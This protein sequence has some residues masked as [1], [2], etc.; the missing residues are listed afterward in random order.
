[1]YYY[2]K[3]LFLKLNNYLSL[4]PSEMK[5]SAVPHFE[6]LGAP[7]GDT[8]FCDRFVSEKCARGPLGCSLNWR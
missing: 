8:I 1:M 4:Y 2:F 7:A 3:L 5:R 6:V